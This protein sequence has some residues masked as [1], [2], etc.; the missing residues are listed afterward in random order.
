MSSSS[1]GE[2]NDNEE[3]VV[4]DTAVEP[5]W[6][7]NASKGANLSLRALKFKVGSLANLVFKALKP[8]MKEK[9][10]QNA[11]LIG[12]HDAGI[13][14]MAEVPVSYYFDDYPVGVGYA[15]IVVQ[16]RLVLELKAV[17]TPIGPTHIN[18][19][20]QY[21]RALNIEEGMVINFGPNQTGRLDVEVFDCAM[22]IGMG[23]Y[24][25]TEEQEE[26]A[27]SGYYGPAP[28]TKRPN[29]DL[30][31]PYEKRQPKRPASPTPSLQTRPCNGDPVQDRPI[32]I[33]EN[34]TKLDNDGR[35]AFTT[36]FQTSQ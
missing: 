9:S 33:V 21:M 29:V 23:N 1:G 18:Q 32:I 36:R 20:K 27:E 19:C 2:E 5:A 7:A 22:G 25:L 35:P 4:P 28:R 17:T 31:E 15:D 26:L 11:M 10:Y 14:A 24:H 34:T 13:V 16:N 8:G 3:V 12:L 6:K 30:T